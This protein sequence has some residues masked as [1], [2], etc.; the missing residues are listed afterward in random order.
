[1]KCNARI[2]YYK[3]TSKGGK[4][5]FAYAISEKGRSSG[6][7]EYLVNEVLSSGKVDPNFEICKG[8]VFG[9][10]MADEEPYFGGTS[11][12]LKVFYTCTDCRCTHYHHLPTENNINAWFND[13]L[14]KNE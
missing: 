1:M 8:D 6:E 12:V 10:I 13:W 11:A 2:Y 5:R 7:I 4:R 3:N 14:N 9:T